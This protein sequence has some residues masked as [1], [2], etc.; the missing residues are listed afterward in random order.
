MQPL[1]RTLGNNI[2]KGTHSEQRSS[3]SSWGEEEKKS[4]LSRV[5]CSMLKK[6]QELKAQKFSVSS[7]A[8]PS[9]CGPHPIL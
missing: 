3:T 5:E 8:D 1:P 9:D 7:V 4:R 2:T 6:W